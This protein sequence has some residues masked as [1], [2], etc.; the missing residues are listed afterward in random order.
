MPLLSTEH[1]YRYTTTDCSFIC[2]SS[3]DLLTIAMLFTLP[4]FHLLTPDIK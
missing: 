1:R 3:F 2:S 4:V